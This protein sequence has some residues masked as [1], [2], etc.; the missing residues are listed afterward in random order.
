[1]QRTALCAREIGAFLNAGIGLTAFPIYECAAADAQ[2]VG[3][4]YLITPEKSMLYF[5]G[6]T[7]DGLDR[8]FAFN[9]AT[10]YME[11]L[12][13]ELA[14]DG[15]R[16][17]ALSPTRRY[18]FCHPLTQHQIALV[19]TDSNHVTVIPLAEPVPQTLYWCGDD[20]LLC[21]TSQGIWAIRR[22]G[23]AYQRLTFFEPFTLIDVAND[24]RHVLLAP[25]NPTNGDI[26]VG[27]VQQRSVTHIVRGTDF[28]QTHEIV[29]PVSWS[30]DSHSIAC[31]GANEQE[32][33]LVDRD[34]RSP[35]SFMRVDYHQ[36]SAFAWAPNGQ[37][38]AA[39]RG[40][41]GGGPSALKVGVFV[42]AIQTGEERQVW[43]LEDGEGMC[44][45][46]AT[47]Q[48]FFYTRPV[49]WLQDVRRWTSRYVDTERIQRTTIRVITL[50]GHD[51]E[52]LGSDQHIVSIQSLIST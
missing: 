11:V 12:G 14:R 19:D 16:Q 23:S 52:L 42:K 33:W 7:Q 31:L 47:S 22:D 32:V 1:M 6:H 49:E 51:M 26:F 48:E 43:T 25:P 4:N 34:G 39:F 45:W 37:S 50:E 27:D 10:R 46:S 2:P 21:N 3:R 41:D 20:W 35:R 18:L 28:E 13:V 38:I 24:A 36:A 9:P 44:G 30:P 8:L 29:Y 17:L 15:Y 5:I 40:L